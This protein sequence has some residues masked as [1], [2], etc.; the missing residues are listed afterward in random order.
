MRDFVFTSE[1]VSAAHPDKLCDQIS[2]A[3][4]DA[5]LM[6][7]PPIGCIAECA[8]ASG[9][10][11]LSVRHGGTLEV[12]PADLAR[13]VLGEAG[14]ADA[15]APTGTTVML[16]LVEAAE[17]TGPVAPAAMRTSHMTTGFGYA[18]NHTTTRTPWPIWAAHA[19]SA[20]LEEEVGKPPFEA[21]TRDAEVQVAVHFENRRPVALSAIALNIFAAE[22]FE[23]DDGLAQLLREHVVRPALAPAIIQPDDA[24][25][26]VVRRAPGAGGPQA[27]A[28]LTGRK[29]ANDTYGGFVRQSSSALSGKD[30]S[31]IDRVAAYAARQAAVSVV[32]AGLADECEVQLSYVAGDRRPI[33]FE[34]DSFATATMSDSDIAATV[35]RSID[36]QIGAIVERLALWR[37]PRLHDGRFYR[38]LARSMHFGRPDLALPWDEP[39]ALR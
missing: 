32:A 11:F 37:L 35:A 9:I 21:L 34:V 20:R 10:V 30:P 12:D 6:A 27:H 36:F 29:V 39:I 14:Y 7:S 38:D 17:L 28:G 19:I 22:S 8:I 23:P 18:C 31:R 3:M 1:A 5:C 33:S 24:T 15:P 4:I 25:R 16:D 13:R 26:F 2:D